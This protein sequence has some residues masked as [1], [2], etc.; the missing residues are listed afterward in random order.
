MS[1]DRVV[2][3]HDFSAEELH[4][5]ICQRAWVNFTYTSKE[6]QA[7]GLSKIR[8]KV[9]ATTDRERVTCSCCLEKINV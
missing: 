9:Y 6:E 2:H 3:F 7:S 4:H 8:E 1:D 5:L